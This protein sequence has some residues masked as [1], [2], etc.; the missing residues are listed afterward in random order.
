MKDKSTV[1]LELYDKF[2]SAVFHHSLLPSIFFVTSRPILLTAPSLLCL[3][4]LP[5]SPCLPFILR[6]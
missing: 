4:Q 2:T 1:T 3:L 5:S 6:M